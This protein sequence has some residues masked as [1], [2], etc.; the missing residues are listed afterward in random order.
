MRNPEWTILDLCCSVIK[1]A[2]VQC[3]RPLLLFRMRGLYVHE[4]AIL[5][6]RWTRRI[7]SPWWRVA[8]KLTLRANYFLLP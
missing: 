8:F 3:C 7:L 1:R 4:L 6:D 2:T 5:H